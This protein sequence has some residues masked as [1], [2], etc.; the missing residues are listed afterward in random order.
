MEP[1]WSLWYPGCS[2][3]VPK[4]QKWCPKNQKWSPQGPKWRSKTKNGAHRV[5]HGPQK[6]LMVPLWYPYGT[7]MVPHWFSFL[8]NKH[9][10]CSRILQLFCEF[11]SNFTDVFVIFLAFITRIDEQFYN[12]LTHVT[13]YFTFL[14]FF[15]SRVVCVFYR[16]THAFLPVFK[17]ITWVF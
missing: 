3:K 7:L 1:K 8:I 5:Q 13:M 9:W 16:K 14:H 11:S 15:N 17:K 10:I 6:A 2:K 4:D 12:I